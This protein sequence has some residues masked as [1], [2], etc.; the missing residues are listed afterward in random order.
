[1]ID[2][3]VL[4][5]LILCRQLLSKPAGQVSSAPG[6][7]HLF[8]DLMI[9]YGA[10]ELA[11]AA[12]C[13]HLDCVPDKKNICLP[14]YFDSL[15]KAAHPISEM[16]GSDYAAELEKVRSES[17]L[18]FHLP[19]AERWEH[20]KVETLAHIS[21]WCRECLGLNIS[22]LASTTKPS[23]ERAAPQKHAGAPKPRYN[24]AGMAEIRLPHRGRSEKGTIANLSLGGCNIKSDF[25]FEVGEEIELI[26]KVNKT[27]FRAAGKVV[28]VPSVVADGRAHATDLGLGVQFK[29]M[30]AGAQTRLQELLSEL[31]THVFRRHPVTS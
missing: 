21:I 1:M 2:R 7:L 14:D 8:E 15:K 19:S 5:Q 18:R 12:M 27:S 30:T 22:D 3:K 23:G 4:D 28:Y 9:C 11:L 6:P 13:V 17:Q 20:A 31:N 24:C 10:A 26:L 29:N 16:P 25:D